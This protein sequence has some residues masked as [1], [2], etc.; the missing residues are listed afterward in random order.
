[1]STI[2]IV[3]G[4]SGCG[5]STVGELLATHLNAPFYDA[6]DFHPPQNIEK[7]AQGSPL[8]DEDRAPW[9]A[10]LRGLLESHLQKREPAV[11][12]CS[13]LKKTYRTTL[14]INANIQ[15]I[16]LHGSFEQIWSRM[17]ARQNHYMKADMLTSQFKTL[18]PPHKTEALTISIDQPLQSILAEIVQTITIV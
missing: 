14:R 10:K 9:L 6:D 4:V 1:M 18:E 13:A 17:Q 7:M 8:N 11:L 15:F 16:Y 5:K 3:M 2:F 12:A